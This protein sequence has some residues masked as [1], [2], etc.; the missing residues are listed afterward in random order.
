MPYDQGANQTK[1][2][3]FLREPDPVPVK[4]SLTDAFP[5]VSKLLA[6]ETESGPEPKVLQ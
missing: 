6:E 2:S 4:F 5:F 3:Y 1:K